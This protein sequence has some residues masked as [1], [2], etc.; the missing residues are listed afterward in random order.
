MFPLSFSVL[1]LMQPMAK[2][3]RL[4]CLCPTLRAIAI[5]SF[6][7]RW[8]GVSTL[9]CSDVGAKIPHLDLPFWP[10]C[11]FLIGHSKLPANCV[12]SSF[13]LCCFCPSFHI[14]APLSSLPAHDDSRNSLLRRP[15][16]LPLAPSHVKVRYPLLSPLGSLSGVLCFSPL[17]PP[18]SR[19]RS[20]C[21]KNWCPLPQTPPCAFFPVK[22]PN[23]TF[24][25][26]TPFFRF[27]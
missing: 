5:L 15:L 2:K 20:S 10:R 22:H 8:C 17:P 21:T 14:F 16:S 18:P 12:H 7:P 3:G 11:A 6:H 9:H 23:A 26:P 24:P 27:L 25:P 4:L 13:L 19:P 1:F